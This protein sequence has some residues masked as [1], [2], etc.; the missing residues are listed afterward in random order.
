[1]EIED[2]EGQRDGARPYLNRGQSS[3]RWTVLRAAYTQRLGPH[4]QTSAS[5]GETYPR[6]RQ[7]P[8]RARGWCSKLATQLATRDRTK[9]QAGRSRLRRTSRP[10]SSRNM[11]LCGEPDALD[12]TRKA[13]RFKVSRQELAPGRLLARDGGPGCSGCGG[14]GLVAATARTIVV[15]QRRR[16]E[17]AP[18]IV[19]ANRRPP[20]PPPPRPQARSTSTTMMM[21]MTMTTRG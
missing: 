1:V 3:A 16:R 5:G 15:F 7:I 13:M 2:E 19:P 8:R 6:F 21:M 4:E 11:D 12:A 18:V 17:D 10:R 20:P 9:P 14:A